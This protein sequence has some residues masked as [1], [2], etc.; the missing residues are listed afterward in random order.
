MDVAGSYKLGT[1]KYIGVT[2]FAAG[3]W[4]GVALDR[5]SGMYTIIT[6]SYNCSM[7]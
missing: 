2:E 3:E 1:I 7:G 6:Y 5:P 4:V